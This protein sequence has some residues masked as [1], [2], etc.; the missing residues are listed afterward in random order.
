MVA[1]ECGGS[2]VNGCELLMDDC[3]E[4]LIGECEGITMIGKPLVNGNEAN[5][6]E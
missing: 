2:R 6:S 4:L 1:R 3:E 5:S